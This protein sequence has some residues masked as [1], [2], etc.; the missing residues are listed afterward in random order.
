MMGKLYIAVRREGNVLVPLAITESLKQLREV[1]SSYHSD[2]VEYLV[3]HG[4]TTPVQD[5]EDHVLSM[6]VDDL[7]WPES[8]GGNFARRQ[9][10]YHD[11]PIVGDVV[12][13]FSEYHQTGVRPPTVGSQHLDQFGKISYRIAREVFEQDLGIELPDIEDFK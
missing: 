2:R 13:Y 7:R 5:I 1:T 3:A 11:L 6:S 10:K 12:R 9:L 4:N 8:R